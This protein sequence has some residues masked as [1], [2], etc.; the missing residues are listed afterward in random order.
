MDR[1]GRIGDD[2]GQVGRLITMIKP[3]LPLVLLAAACSSDVDLELNVSGPES[4]RPSEPQTPAAPDPSLGPLAWS[5]IEPGLESSEATHLERAANGSVIAAGGFARVDGRAG[6]NAFV[7]RLSPDGARMWL[8]EIERDDLIDLAGGFG[9]AVVEAS[10]ASIASIDSFEDGRILIALN[11]SAELDLDPGEYGWT[12]AFAEVG[13]LRWYDADGNLLETRRFPDD[14]EPVSP[15]DQ[16]IPRTQVSSVLALPDGGGLLAGL[17]GAGGEDTRAH[18]VRF[19]AGGDPV[20]TTI[21]DTGSIVSDL[22]VA[23]DGGVLVH[24][25]FYQQI[26]VG[27]RIAQGYS[28]IGSFVARLE[29]D[30]GRCAWL[31]IFEDADHLLFRGGI[32]VTAGGHVVAA[33]AFYGGHVRA[34]EFELDATEQGDNYFLSELGPDGEVLSL[35]EIDPLQPMMGGVNDRLLESASVG[36]GTVLMGGLVTEFNEDLTASFRA[37]FISVFDLDGHLLAERRMLASPNELNHGVART[38]TITPDG[39]VLTGGFWENEIDLG[40]GDVLETTEAQ[41]GQ[42]FVAL[43]HPLEDD[44]TVDRITP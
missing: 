42:L 30:T 35:A 15:S 26:T 34:G 38:V 17:I 22:T 39:G 40:D 29:G 24:G 21:S 36:D 14:A 33:G 19:D 7:A 37:A 12:P 28:G 43:Y 5:F 9:D 8:T 44:T 41:V 16:T 18:I 25:I 6:G 11:L 27:E 4:E 20:W 32:G 10:M 13:F 31:Q 3:S 1:G 23:P 2:P